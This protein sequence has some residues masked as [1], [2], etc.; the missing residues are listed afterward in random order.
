MVGVTQEKEKGPQEELANA[1]LCLRASF[2]Y[3]MKGEGK[4]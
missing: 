1:V 2:L 3:D 4:G